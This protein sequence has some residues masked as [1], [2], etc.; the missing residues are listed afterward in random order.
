M[1]REIKFRGKDLEYGYWVYGD[2]MQHNDGDVLIGIHNQH[3]TDDGYSNP[4]YKEVRNVD[5]DTVGQYT[6]IKSFEGE[7]IYE[8]DIIMSEDSK[9]ESIYHVVFYDDKDASFKAALNGN[10]NASFGVCNIT[11]QWV[12]E[13]EKVLVG[14]LFDNPE[15][16]V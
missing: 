9:G 2:L 11:Q 14:N 15:V 1:N 7:R 10:K 12:D 4:H 6:G 13:F 3:W 8:G 5:E 16:L